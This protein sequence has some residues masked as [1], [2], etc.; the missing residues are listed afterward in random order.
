MQDDNVTVQAKVRD[1]ESRMCQL[2]QDARQGNI[3]ILC[4]PEHRQENLVSAVIQLGKAVS[5]TVSETEI[6]SCTRVQKLDSESK[7]PRTVVCKLPSKIK[8][9]GFLVAVYKYN[10]QNPKEKLNTKLL[11]YGD[12]QTPIY[13]GEHLT[14]ANKALHAASRRKN[15]KFVWIR[16]GRIFVRK[17]ENS[18]RLFINHMEALKNLQ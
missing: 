3:K 15:Y 5:F 12:P 17:D 8:R 2:E 10:R 6:L 13:V 11:G 9:D 18:P 7:K 16:N 4:L 14:Q 1:M